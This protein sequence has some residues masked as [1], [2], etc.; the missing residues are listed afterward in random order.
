MRTALPFPDLT[1]LG[2]TF[3]YLWMMGRK[4]PFDR[5]EREATRVAELGDLTVW[6]LPKR[7]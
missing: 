2:E 4:D 5:L 3:D 7:E 6:K 1:E